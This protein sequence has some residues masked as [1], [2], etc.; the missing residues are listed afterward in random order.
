LICASDSVREEIMLVEEDMG[1]SSVVYRRSPRGS[2]T[3]TGLLL[4]STDMGSI[5]RDQNN[6]RDTA[7]PVTEDTKRPSWRKPWKAVCER[8]WT[9][10]S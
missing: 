5:Y 4:K 7:E 3:L 1:L 2:S 8:G 10:W 6:G 9:I